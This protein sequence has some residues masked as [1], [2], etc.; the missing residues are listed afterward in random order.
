M[1]R[2]TREWQS[3]DAAWGLVAGRLVA[4]G[5]AGAALAAP[6]LP[7]QQAATWRQ[8]RFAIGGYFTE[9][10]G[11]AGDHA[12]YT[13]LARP[14]RIPPLCNHCTRAGI[15]WRRCHHACVWRGRTQRPTTRAG[16][17]ADLAARLE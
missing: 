8:P 7:Q 2:T 3:A 11:A 9:F 4:L 10:I 1:T 5:L 17:A 6:A 16:H 14:S 15:E 13:P 12:P